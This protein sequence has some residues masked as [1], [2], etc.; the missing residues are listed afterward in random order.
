MGTM[1]KPQYKGKRYRLDKP[2]LLAPAGNLEKLKFAVHYGADAVYI[3]GQKYGLRSGADNFSFEEMREGV[4]FAKKYGAKVFV[5]TN[6]Y[7]HNEDIAGIEE[8]LRNLHKAGIAAIIVADPAIVDTARRLVPELEVHLSTQQSTLNWQAVSFWKEEGLPRV[9]LG[10]ETSLE[11]IAEIKQHVDI[12][13]ESFIHGAM[14]SSYSGRC[15]LSNHFTDRDSNRGGCCQSCRWKYDLFEDGRPEG[16]W[17][18]EEEQAEAAPP[19]H[20]LPGVTQLPLHQPEDNQFS[21]GSKDLCMLESIPDL[22]EVGIDS[23]KIEGRMKSVHYVATVVNAYRK[24]IDAYMADPDNYVLNPEWLE[25]LQKAANRPLNTGFFYDTPDH[26]DHIYEPE[27]KAAPYDFAGLVLEYD[28]D[29][30][31]ALIQQRNHFKPGQEVEFFGPD[32]TSFKQTVGELWD[33]EGNKL[34][35]ARHPLQKIRMKVDHPVAYF[36]MMR[37][38][39]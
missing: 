17:V 10:R 33:E 24:A 13:I 11:E 19:Q 23:F 9:V 27:E 4:E 25:E 5:A 16:N 14:C 28:A 38:R 15:V 20:L 30:G 22:I 18:S 29:T 39:K 7:A 32:I 35:A 26:E 12:E 21:M 1:T 3:G 2:E 36:D 6:I 37:K 31:M 8:Y 34:D